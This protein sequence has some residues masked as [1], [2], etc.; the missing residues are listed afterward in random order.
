[1]RTVIAEDA[2]NHHPTRPPLQQEDTLRDIR[3]SK[4]EEKERRRK[5]EESAAR[6][7]RRPEV[8]A[9][10]EERLRDLA[11]AAL[12]VALEMFAEQVGGGAGSYR[13]R[14]LTLD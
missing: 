1:M 6:T 3:A 5:L 7:E 4:E 10:D 13:C 12:K 9:E 8:V 11:W 14:W 2:Q